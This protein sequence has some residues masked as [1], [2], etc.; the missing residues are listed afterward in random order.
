[1]VPVFPASQGG[2]PV[3]EAVQCVVGMVVNHQSL[4]GDTADENRQ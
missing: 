4:L 3:A 1:M 2:L